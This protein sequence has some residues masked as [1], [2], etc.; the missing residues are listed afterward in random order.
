[1]TLVG[2][3][4]RKVTPAGVTVSEQQGFSSYM[5]GVAAAGDL[6]YVYGSNGGSGAAVMWSNFSTQGTLVSAP[7]GS[8]VGKPYAS[9][10]GFF[11]STASEVRKAS[12][13]ASVL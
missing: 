1:M 3:A 11:W 5:T 6:V 10:Q 9:T 7:S 12:P 13:P 2:A 8:I 4:L